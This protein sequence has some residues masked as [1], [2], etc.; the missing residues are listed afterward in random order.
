VIDTGEL[1]Q[2]ER[3]NDNAG[4]RYQ[5]GL[6]LLAYVRELQQR[7]ENLSY[8]LRIAENSAEQVR[9]PLQQI[10]DI[11]AQHQGGGLETSKYVA[12]VHYW[13]DA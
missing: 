7:N 12:G 5:D 2:I 11:T 6:K 3:D 8:R 1:E 13:A 4:I 9:V 10:R